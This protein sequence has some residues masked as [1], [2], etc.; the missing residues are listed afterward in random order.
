[1]IF[2]V[3]II[4]LFV[5]ACCIPALE[6]RSTNNPHDVMWGANAL[7]VGWSGIF[8]GVFAW[9]ANPV[10]LLGLLLGVLRKPI[11]VV[12]VG[13]IAVFIASTTFLVI[14]RE[15]PGDE[16]NVTRT[17][18]V[19]LLPGCYLWMASMATLPLAALFYK[20]SR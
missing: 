8:A 1:M 13:V 17:T 9:Y 5:I 12:V 6:F 10:W 4:V 3:G 16:S 20:P 11:L 14:G 2:P 18:V 15:L 7:V 19:R